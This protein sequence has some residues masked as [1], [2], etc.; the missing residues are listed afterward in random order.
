[1]TDSKKYIIHDLD[2]TNFPKEIRLSNSDMVWTNDGKPIF[3][4]AKVEVCNIKEDTYGKNMYSMGLK[5]TDEKQ[6]NTLKEIIEMSTKENVFTLDDENKK[7]YKISVIPKEQL[8]Q[9]KLYNGMFYV[10]FNNEQL[11]TKT[12]LKNEF[13]TG[14]INSYLGRGSLINCLMTIKVNFYKKK[15][16]FYPVSIYLEQNVSILDSKTTSGPHPFLEGF[17][18]LTDYKLSDEIVKQN[19]TPVWELSKLDINKI[20]FSNVI[21]KDD[22]I[23]MYINTGSTNGRFYAQVE[24]LISGYSVKENPN[25][26]LKRKISISECSENEFLLDFIEKIHSKRVS[27]LSECSQTLYNDTLDI[28]TILETTHNPLYSQEDINKFERR[29]SMTLPHMNGKPTFK[30]FEIINEDDKEFIIPVELGDNFNITEQYIDSGTLITS[31]IF[32]MDVCFVEKQSYLRII[33]EQILINRTHTR[34]YTSKLNKFAFP[35]YVYTD[36]TKKTVINITEDSISFNKYDSTRK[37]LDFIFENEDKKSAYG[38]LP[39]TLKLQYDFNYT[40]F[41]DDKTDKTDKTESG[42]TKNEKYSLNY[43]LKEEDISF[44]NKIDNKIINYLVKNSKDIFGS[45]KNEKTIKTMIDGGQFVKYSNLD[46]DKTKPFGKLK[47]PTFDD[48]MITFEVYQVI[49]TDKL[50]IEK[51]SL[52]NKEDLL[53]LLVKGTNFKVIGNMKIDYRN[54]KLYTSFIVSQILILP[55][56]NDVSIPFVDVINENEDIDKE[57]DKDKDNEFDKDNNKESDKDNEFDKDNNKES[58]KD[59]NKES[60][61]ESNNESDNESEESDESDD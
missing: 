8:E 12:K 24:S 52:S 3:F 7:K 34:V 53:P 22:R 18:F 48:K 1:M 19:K 39:I 9:T 10:K 35:D 55:S 46:K 20:S 29:C 31:V 16:M 51:V 6:L 27:K 58:D 2:N 54:N 25:F 37:S 17:G 60:D 33:I 23:D 59:N 30:M 47:I 36:K 28:E 41:N 40:K 57:S 56:D 50:K 45:T 38:F 26:P 11:S 44:F 21:K 32:K 15:N 42:K 13:I 4:K 5:F 14:K 49:D 43:Y 61:K